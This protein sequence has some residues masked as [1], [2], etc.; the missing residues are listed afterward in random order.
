MTQVAARQL[1]DPL[2]IEKSL[3]EEIIRVEIK[4]FVVITDMEHQRKGAIQPP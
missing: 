4:D 3:M 1:D 2:K